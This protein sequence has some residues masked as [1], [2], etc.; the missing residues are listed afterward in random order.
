LKSLYGFIPFP[1]VCK[2]Y[3][4]TLDQGKFLTVCGK[5]GGEIE[6]CSHNDPRVSKNIAVPPPDR[7]IFVCKECDQPYWWNDR[8]NSSPAKAMKMADRLYTAVSR[9]IMEDEKENAPINDVDLE[10]LSEE[11]IDSADESDE[12]LSFELTERITIAMQSTEIKEEN[13]DVFLTS[14]KHRRPLSTFA[15]ISTS[16][17]GQVHSLS[18]SFSK[19]DQIVKRKTVSALQNIES[20][21]N[22]HGDGDAEPSSVLST[23]LVQDAVRCSEILESN[24]KCEDEVDSDGTANTDISAKQEDLTRKDGYSPRKFRSA[25][26]AIHDGKEARVT[27]WSSDFKE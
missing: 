21:G 14:T 26:A 17:P 11:D 19:R 8:E 20:N 9:S 13:L 15:S 3:G 27:N 10:D 23:L 6:S 2:E 7:E 25:F 12:P 4:L 18:A 5:C 16:E 22:I 24:V 1:Q